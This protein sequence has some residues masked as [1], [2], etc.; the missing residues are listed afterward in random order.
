MG[1]FNV[2]VTPVVAA[3]KQHAEGFGTGEVLFDWTAIQVPKGTSCLK[4]ITGMI[5]PKGDATPTINAQPFH[6][7]FSKSNTVSL[8]TVNADASHS[9]NN[10][11]IGVVN[12]NTNMYGHANTN[13]TAVFSTTSIDTDSAGGMT[14]LIMTPT[15]TTGDNAGYDTLY[16]AALT[17]DANTTFE[18][19]NV[20][21]DTDI[22]S[23]TPTAIVMAGTSMDVRHH[24]AIGDVLH[25]QDDILLGTVDTI[26]AATTGPINLTAATSGAGDATTVANG[27]TVYNIYPIRLILGFEK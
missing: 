21:N 7:Y 25:A 16:V 3:S 9:P 4:S 19:I 12:I 1:Y 15:V 24:F 5:R 11:F 17:G 8:G 13:G 27:D 10:D 26:S 23:T 6:I 14:P 22:N 20:I 18:S 2:E